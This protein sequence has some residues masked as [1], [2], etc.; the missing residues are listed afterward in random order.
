MKLTARLPLLLSICLMGIQLQAQDMLTLEQAIALALKNNY[1]IRL[2]RNDSSSAMID[3]K[4]QNAGFLPRLTATASKTWNNNAQKQQLANGTTKDTSGIR[5]NNLP[6]AVTLQWT[7]F[8]GLKMFA[9]RDKILEMKELGDLGVKNQVVNTV[10]TVINNYYGIVRQKQQLKAIIEQKSISEERVKLADKK[11][12]VGLGAKPEL[13][14]A[15]VDLNAFIASQLQQNTLIE[16]L[17]IQLNQLIGID[18]MTYYDVVD[19]I[20]INDELQLGEIRNNLSLSNPQ[21][22]IAQKNISIS[23]L[24]YKERRGELF[25]VLY[26]NSAYS[27]SRTVNHMVINTFTPLYNRNNGLNYGLSLSFPFLNAFTAKR[28]VQQARLDILYQKISFDNQRTLLDVQVNNTFK[29]Y[30]LQ[31]RYLTLE[32]DNIKL[33]RE[34]VFIA[35]ER[36]KQGV[37]TYIELREAQLSL[38][39][40]Y[41]RLIAARYNAK[42]AETELMRLKGDLVK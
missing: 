13:L 7:L 30:E 4:Y 36:F 6:A 10:A 33:A 38:N 42:L 34:N 29:N 15:K 9:T 17:K 39:D 25:P 24:T 23:E 8:D 3:Y 32:E 21:L 19:T 11:L 22:Q 26:F 37:S 27:Y 12:S 31:K 1:D 2:S 20:P 35:L 28:A 18:S 40:A 41:N 5:S 14:Q 16:Q